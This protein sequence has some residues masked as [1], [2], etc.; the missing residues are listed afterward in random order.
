MISKFF[1]E[2]P[3]LSNVI[4]ILMI[5]IG[6][7]ALFNLA[8]AQYPD[9]VPPTVQVTTRY[10]G[11][12]A[13]T[14][15][16]TVAL[17]IEQQVNGVEDML[18]MQ[19]YSGAD[20]TYTLTVTFKIG[21]DL[22]FAQV[23]VQNRVSSALSQLPTAVQ[24]QGVTVQKRSTS[25]LL[26]VTL[27]SPNKTYDSL[28]LSNYATINIRDELSRLPGVGNVTVFGAGQYSMRVWLDPNKLQA[29]GLMPQDVIQAIQQQS[30]QVTA[31]QVG[32]PPA[33]Q[34]QA[35]QY[36][37]NVNGRLDDAS[38]FEN[39]I[40]KTGNVGD[41]IR[42]RDLGSV[43]LGAQTYSQ[44]FSL[45]QK[46]ATG[47]GVFLSPGANALQVEKEV[48]KK[49][50]Q[51]ARQFPQDIQ[52]DTPFDTT[53]F[54]NASIEEVYKTLIEAG[55]LV[56]V[57]ILVFLQDWRAMLVPA[58]TV[59]VTIIDAFAAMAA[60]GFTINLSTLFAIVL[61]IGIVV[62]DAIVVVEGAAHNIERGM[63]GHDAAI[64][65]MDELFAPIVGITL[66]L[67]S[68]FLPAAFLPGLTGRMYAQFALVIAATA[69]LSAV[70]AATL[71]PMQCALWL[72]PP[73]PAEQRNF[74]YRGFNA[75]Y[76][77]VERGYT[78]LVGGMAGHAKTSVL[79]ALILIGIAGYGLS[80]VPTG[81]IPI[82]DQGYLLAAVQLPD[83][84]AIDRTQRVLDQVTEIARKTPGVEQVVAIAGISALDN[85]SSLANAG[86][87]YVI[88]KDWGSRGPGE[89]LRSLVYGLNDKLAVIPEARILVIP[90][91]PIQG[92]GNAAG[93]AMQVQLRDGNADYG[94]LQAVTG[95]VVSNAQTQSALQRVQSS[96]RSMVPQ[97]D[98]QVDRVKTETLHVTTDQIFSTLSSYLGASYVNQFT[99]FGRTFQV[100][101]QADAQY[102]LTLRDIENMMVRNSNG[103]MVPLG[104][105]AKITPSVGP[106][107]ISLYNLYPSATIIGLP[108]QGYSSGQSMTLMEEIAAKTLPPG[109]GF[110]WTAMSYQEKEVGSQIYFV[111]ALALLLVYLVL[112]GQY[113]SW[114][115]PISVILA[116]PLS[117]LGPMLVLTALR[118]EN[119]LYTQ[120]GTILLIALSAKNAILIV[121]VAL[122]HHIRD[123]KPVLESAIDAARA[124]FRP[125]L[126][127]S[128][129]FILGVL[130]LVLATGAGAN[131]RK[132]IGI[133]VF[134]GMIASTCLAVLFVPAFFV[135]VQS[136]ENWRKAK[137]GKTAAP[138]PAAPGT[139]H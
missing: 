131:A 46:P 10:P 50:A 41:V 38:Q 125:I 64:K 25:I 66:V 57:V 112:A 107:L 119:N 82:E 29:R 133:T 81:F 78:R 113:E 83:G 37:L 17:P 53:K 26:F 18:Y 12:S 36:T 129:A 60:L 87:A 128:F 35:F 127:T 126:M 116:V 42:I 9:V 118:I 99:K 85:S 122:E 94:K 77:R 124:R 63:S 120:I 76:D 47:I 28:F 45:N 30:Q 61:A 98:V 56:L 39:I 5:L 121:E 32:A 80:R 79:V 55:L 134:S 114:Y 91:P 101:T 52:Y 43:E 67:I 72:R 21:T 135:V 105:V 95:A 137:K 136:F 92:I 59:P 11:A 71:K 20:G 34:G 51:L 97:F 44:V 31:G 123:G 90:P 110:E 6:G 2:R 8:V 54:V 106:S 108:S 132:S 24:N 1:I 62:D 68:V 16:D 13:K 130:P 65:A 138:Q 86:V 117:L 109:T 23:L 139:V 73:V 69:L 19:S 100:Y 70:N 84:A 89:D 49:V 111:F 102:R 93:F 115:A 104:T 96:F 27:T 74:F 40:V 48:Q 58:T 22:N 103:D 88:L 3:V 14:V 33:P 4:A 75:V 7:V 15:I